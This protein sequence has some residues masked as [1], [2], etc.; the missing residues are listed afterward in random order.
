MEV[1]YGLHDLPC[2][3]QTKV[4]LLDLVQLEEDLE[5]QYY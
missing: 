4:C 1:I 5:V 2:F 3:F